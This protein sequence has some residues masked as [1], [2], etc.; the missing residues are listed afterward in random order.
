MEIVPNPVIEESSDAE[1]DAEATE[2]EHQRR[3]EE[4]Q[5]EDGH[6]APLHGRRKRRREWVYRPLDDDILIQHDLYGTLDGVETPVRIPL[7]NSAI[8]ETDTVMNY[9]SLREKDASSQD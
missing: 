9:H 2:G 6:A 5:A 8:E 1:P 3:K 4:I 7:P